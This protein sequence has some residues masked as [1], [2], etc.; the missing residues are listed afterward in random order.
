MVKNWNFFGLNFRIRLQY[1][2]LLLALIFLII[3]TVVNTN[4]PIFDEILF[5]R[6]MPLFKEHGLSAK[7]LREMYDQAPGPL[8]QI[9]QTFFEPLTNLKVPG[10]RLVNVFLFILVIVNTYFIL[11]ITNSSSKPFLLSLNLIAVPVMWQV[12][13]M[14]LTEMP[15]MF[16]LTCSL[17]ILAYLTSHV[18]GKIVTPRTLV[19]S[20]ISGLCLGMS[21]LGRTP[22]LMIVPA[23]ILLVFNPLSDKDNKISLSPPLIIVFVASALSVSLPVFFIWQGL[24]PPHQTII[25]QGGLKL[26]HG[27][28]AFAYSGIIAFLIA[29]RWFSFSKNWAIILLVLSILFFLLN[30]FWWQVQYQPLYDF[31]SRNLPDSVMIIYPRIISP[32][33]MTIATFFAINLLIYLS[34]N[35]NKSYFLF[36]A[37]SFILVLLTCINVKHI[38][39]SRYVAQAM[40]LFVLLVAE[41]DRDNRFKIVRLLIGVAMGYISL[42]TYADPN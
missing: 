31:L 30:S 6:N 10:I 33:L 18:D 36:V 21:I 35:R 27:V 23:A 22:F 26:W 11:K 39:S 40:P 9:V 25:S 34:E 7:F 24:V 14:A 15:A 17:L 38:F 32:L 19:F 1:W 4:P 29:P 2:V 37:A 3:L 42:Q 5:V 41:K 8:Y 28:L 13:G 12:A 20:L 16:F